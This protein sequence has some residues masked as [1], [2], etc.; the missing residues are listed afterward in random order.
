M[1][2][3]TATGW[4]HTDGGCANPNPRP[5]GELLRPSFCRY[6]ARPVE[7]IPDDRP[8]PDYCAPCRATIWNHELHDAMHRA[9]RTRA[10][11]D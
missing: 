8:D 11:E 6:C 3:E 5:Y 7:I 10:Q 1:M 2:P 9:G 4:R